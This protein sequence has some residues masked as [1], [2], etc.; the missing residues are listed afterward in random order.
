MTAYP[1]SMDPLG[2]DQILDVEG[3]TFSS[4]FSSSS[5]SFSAPS[6]GKGIAS[7]VLRTPAPQRLSIRPPQP[8]NLD[9]F[10]GPSHQY[11]DHRQQTSLPLGGLADS[12]AATRQPNF[13]GYGGFHGQ[14]RMGSSS[15]LPDLTLNDDSFDF[16]GG[17]SAATHKTSFSAA[18]DVDMDFDSGDG[19]FSFNDTSPGSDTIDPNA[20]G[21][22]EDDSP[23]PVLSKVEK[24]WPGHHT[25]QA[26]L[27]KQQ[28]EQQQQQQQQEMKPPASKAAPASANHKRNASS[29]P[30]DP[31]MEK[32]ISRILDQMRHNSDAGA[33][34]S[35]PP[36]GGLPH[37]ARAKKDEE[38]MD[39]DERLLASEEGKKLSSKERRQLRNKV[40]AR[41]F[42]SR[43]KGS[44]QQ[45]PRRY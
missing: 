7:P 5:S 18:S 15:G 1:E 10:A 44:S 6:K 31:D 38:D 8:T 30:V 45:S 11:N 35:P 25:Q 29:R 40:S 21:G 2:I 33:D 16:G 12:L 14:Y 27:A 22:Q 20:L 9:L 3:T 36:I 34:A 13:G 4:P 42:R 24:V 37:V 41:A 43:R 19:F 28:Q 17:H 23:T 32:S 26:A 39:D